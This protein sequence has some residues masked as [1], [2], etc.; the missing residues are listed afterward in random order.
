MLAWTLAFTEMTSWG[1]LY[2]TFSVIFKPMQLELGW[3]PETLTG[4]FSIALLVSGFAA[5][6]VA[7]WL[8]HYGARV[9]MTLGSILAVIGIIGWSRAQTKTQFYAAWIVIGL[10]MAGVL[11]DPALAVIT[12][13]FTRQRSRALTILTF[14]GGLASVIFVPFTTYL[15]N[16]RGRCL[17]VF[18]L[19]FPC[20]FTVP[21]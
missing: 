15:L 2:Y 21:A 16:I 1:I 7:R 18:C 14:G 19:W 13:W 6:P 9:V 4:A 12:I 20:F 11:Y 17:A 5:I 3:S 10:A 8:T